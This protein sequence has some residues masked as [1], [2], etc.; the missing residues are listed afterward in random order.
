VSCLKR[1]RCQERSWHSLC[2]DDAA[3]N[4]VLTASFGP[5][6]TRSALREEYI[7]LIQLQKGGLY[8][9]LVHKWGHEIAEVMMEIAAKREIIREAKKWKIPYDEIEGLRNAIV[10]YERTL[11]KLTRKD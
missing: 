10:D 1:K 9:Q 3:G 2:V 11:A 8:D 5:S 7:H 6:P 4:Q